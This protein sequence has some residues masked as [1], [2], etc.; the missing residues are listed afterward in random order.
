MPLDME[1]HRRRREGVFCR[2]LASLNLD[3]P[4]LKESISQHTAASFR[5]LLTFLC[6]SFSITDRR[7]QFLHQFRTGRLPSSITVGLIPG[8]HC[9]GYDSSSRSLSEPVRKSTLLFPV[10]VGITVRI[11][12]SAARIN[13]TFDHYHYDY[14]LHEADC[15]CLILWPVRIPHPLE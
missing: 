9:R 6:P 4:L 14:D 15:L 8:R 11:R 13:S 1:P 12:Q 2:R 3:W 10:N 5:F 7:Y